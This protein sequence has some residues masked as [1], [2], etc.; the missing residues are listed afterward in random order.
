L[1]S[2]DKKRVL[3]LVFQSSLSTSGHGAVRFFVSSYFNAML[4]FCEVS[5]YCLCGS[6]Y[7]FYCLVATRV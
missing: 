2:E 7:N 1:Q 3:E 4:V 6:V 5:G